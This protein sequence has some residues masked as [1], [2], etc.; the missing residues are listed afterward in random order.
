MSSTEQA[1]LRFAG[2]ED[3]SSDDLA[4]A[5]LET[6]LAAVAAA[7]DGV[8]A[9]G[10]P[11]PVLVLAWRLMRPGVMRVA[12]ASAVER[13]ASVMPRPSSVSRRGSL[14]STTPR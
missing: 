2:I 1:A 5:L 4:A 10:N 11:A 7:C 12:A 14:L 13:S 6:Q 9:I 8:A 3:W